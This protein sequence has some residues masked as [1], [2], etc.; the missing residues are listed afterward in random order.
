MGLST[1]QPDV[2][3]D[4]LIAGAGCAGASAALEL[5][6][7]GPASMRI[8]VV[9]PRGEFPRDRTWCFWRLAV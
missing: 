5:L 6:E 2:D 1:A 3:F 4:L 9:D 7:H 8:A